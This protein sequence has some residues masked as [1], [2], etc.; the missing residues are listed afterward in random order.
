MKMIRN[1]FYILPFL[2][3]LPLL[4]CTEKT[5]PIDDDPSVIPTSIT[6]SKV[7]TIGSHRYVEANGKPYLSY[8]VHL[9]TDDLIG[10]DYSVQSILKIEEYFQKAA[11][12]GFKTVIISVPWS[13][14]ETSEGVYDFDLFLRPMLNYAYK[15][16]LDI[17]INWFGSTLCGW[18]GG[19]SYI[20]ND[21]ITY[22]R[23]KN[24]ILTDSYDFTNTTVVDK[25][26]LALKAL[27]NFI[28]K[29]DVKRRIISICTAV[30]PNSW[31]INN[32]AWQGQKD[33][34]INNKLAPVGKAL[35][36][37]S[38]KMI[39]KTYLSS[40]NDGIG[41][42]LGAGGNDIVGFDPYKFTSSELKAQLK[43]SM[44]GNNIPQI[45]E[46][47][48]QYDSYIN[49]VLSTF[50][51]GAGYYT[52][53]LKTFNYRN[54]DFGIYRTTTK[55]SNEWIER[56]GT[57]NVAYLWDGKTPGKESNTPE[58]RLFNKMIYKANQKIAA[59]PKELSVGFNLANNPSTSETIT[60]AGKSM[61]FSTVVKGCALILADATD[62]SIIIL[63]ARGDI[64]LKFSSTVKTIPVS[65][66]GFNDA[67]NWIEQSTR[68]V[69]S[70]N[71]SLK[72]WEVV[73]ILPF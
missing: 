63:A 19:P 24:G 73:K 51:E 38:P 68:N 53:E 54:Y 20:I 47:G 67:N 62:N 56:D 26:I 72:T 61:Q 31:S 18:A 70:D 23:I 58:I 4:A 37:Y 41:D 45:C 27:M 12:V 15:Y 30:E 71:I 21:R 32:I 25:E 42:I 10:S 13:K 11:D 28:N 33:A 1:I 9:R 36:T 64:V 7:I 39:V 44:V 48:G 5:P 2:I 49:L 40:V 46:N 57:Q 22:P 59:C 69:S 17:E 29:T 43:T 50:D 14:I 35:Q 60:L 6:V 34:I 66:G 3:I 65:V 55:E 16:N 52:Y 8:G